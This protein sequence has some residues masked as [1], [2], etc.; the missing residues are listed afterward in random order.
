ML[1]RVSLLG[2][3]EAAIFVVEFTILIVA[4]AAIETDNTYV[5]VVSTA[6]LFGIAAVVALYGHKVK[7]WYRKARRR[8]VLFTSRLVRLQKRDEGKVFSF[9]GTTFLILKASPCVVQSLETGKCYKADPDYVFFRIH[10]DKE[11]QADF[12]EIVGISER[13]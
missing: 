7:A 3:A 2:I 4:C 1:K 13:R 12:E 10:M 5:Y 6:S 11:V 9:R 8:A